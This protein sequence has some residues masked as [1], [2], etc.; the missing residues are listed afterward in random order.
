MTIATTYIRRPRSLP[1]SIRRGLS[2]LGLRLRAVGAMRGLGKSAAIL[3]ALAAV[4]MAADV[5]FA[6]PPSAR[7]TIWAAWIATAAIGLVAGVIRPMVRRLAWND[8][9]ALAEH[10]EPSLGER[11]TTAV[12]LLR[13][14]PHGSPELIAAVVDDAAARS[15]QVDLSRAVSM[16]GSLVWLMAG[17]ILAGLVIA[18]AVV[19]PDPFANIGKRFLFPRADIDRVSRFVVE[20]APGDKVVAVGSDVSVSAIVHSRFGEPMPRGDAWL[21]WTGTDGK[22][23]RVRLAA[24]ARANADGPQG[25]VLSRRRSR[26]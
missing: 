22:P 15:G 6:L 9:A 24:N 8:L 23:H 7:W 17:G 18:P 16:R 13:Q 26:D 2:R 1:G 11:L 4:A 12:G 19:R 10:G 20:V 14:E 3:A 5:A 25:R 21:E